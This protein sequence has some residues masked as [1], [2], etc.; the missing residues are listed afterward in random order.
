MAGAAVQALHQLWIGRAS[1]APRRDESHMEEKRDIP[2]E[3]GSVFG[4]AA[5]SLHPVFGS[6]FVYPK[7]TKTDGK[8]RNTVAYETGFIPS[9]FNFIYIYILL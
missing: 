3:N 9:V 1:T 2:V 7:K 6:V 4:P 8:I 5:G